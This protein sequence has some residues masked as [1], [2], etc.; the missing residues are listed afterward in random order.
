M[1]TPRTIKTFTFIVFCFFFIQHVYSQENFIKGFVTTTNGDTLNGF[2]DYK[3]WDKNPNRI[4]FQK[5][6]SNKKLS[7]KP[8]SILGFGVNGDYYESGVVQIELSSNS[9]I[10][11]TTLKELDMK[12]DSV[13]LEAIFRGNKSLYSY[14]TEQIREQFYIKTNGTFELLIYKRYLRNTEEQTKI[15]ENATY[16]SQLSMYL[17]DMPNLQPKL[18]VTEYTTKS[19]KNLFEYYYKTSESTSKYQKQTEKVVFEFGALAG[20]SIFNI[21]FEGRIF[22]ELVNG[23]FN[24]SINPMGGVYFDIVF[25]RNQKRWSLHNELVYDSFKTQGYF[26]EYDYEEKYSTYDIKLD[27]AYLKLVNMFRYKLFIGK[28]DVYVNAGLSNGWAIKHDRLLEKKSRLFATNRTEILDPIKE[29]SNYEQGYIIGLGVKYKKINFEIRNER[30]TG[31]SEYLSLVS[32]T[33][34]LSFLIGYQF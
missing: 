34:R 2:I 31:M 14:K 24:R 11:L 15:I 17:H 26:M 23:G 8:S 33:N 28:A 21:K 29:S 13:F 6:N 1:T 16:L 19:L 32:P 7:L 30:G 10:D 5:I 20:V 25:P 27:Y 12:T 9:T 22:P 3:N 4:T 18:K